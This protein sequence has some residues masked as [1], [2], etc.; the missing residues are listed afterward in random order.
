MAL[1][2]LVSRRF[3]TFRAKSE[4]NA[5]RQ[6]NTVFHELTKQV[7]WTV[8]D[9]LVEKHD[10]DR[11]VRRLTCRNQFLAL[12]F[13]QLAGAGSLREIE[14]G[15]ASHRARLHHAGARPAARATLADAN[16]KRPAALFA[17]LFAHMAAAAARPLR[18]HMRDAT[19]I[20]DATTVRLTGLSNDWA[21][22]GDSHAAAKLHLV[23][24]PA[25]AAPL[26]AEVTPATVNDITPAKRREITP[27]ATYVF[28]LG[29]YDY[30]W[31]AE[32]DA[33]NCRIVTR[34]KDNTR[35][36]DVVEE[37]QA[38]GDGAVLGAV[39]SERIGWLPERMARARRNPMAVPLREITVR[40]APEKTIRLVTNDLDSPA[41][42]IAEIYRQRW[43]IE[44]FFKWIKQ[45][46][47]IRRFLGTSENAV[48][49]QL[50]VALIAYLLLRLAHKAQDSV[51]RPSAFILLVRLNIAQRRPIAALNQPP[52]PPPT[53]HRQFAMAISP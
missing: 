17:E 32:L 4:I 49:I 3:A 44:L 1:I 18:R 8:F 50:Y 41:E 39:R 6:H 5:M 38:P 25:A 26:E 42:E 40:I 53:D 31:W 51:A 13:G 45:N 23:Y 52:P 11:G 24:D 27:G 21:K 9:R 36:V 47:R 14:A 30:G 35:L 20:L 19:R 43:Q 37:S 7:P 33:R 48:R 12:L 34:L 22:I 15:L 10:A 29:Y 16:A 46:L 2:L 28:D